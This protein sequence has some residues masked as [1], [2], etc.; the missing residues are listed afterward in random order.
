MPK[1]RRR[2]KLK[3]SDGE[4]RATLAR[5]FSQLFMGFVA[6][7]CANPKDEEG[8]RMVQDMIRDAGIRG[9]E[10]YRKRHSKKR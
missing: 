3:L 5:L 8:V 4:V 10:S 1:K 7:M 9:A 2:R 6:V